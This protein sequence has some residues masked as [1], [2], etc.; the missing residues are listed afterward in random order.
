[1]TVTLAEPA[2]VEAQPSDQRFVIGGVGWDSYVAISDALDERPGMR[3]IYCVGRLIF[4]G[5]SRRH[6]W[7][8][9]RLGEL[10]K[11]LAR[12]LA[13]AWEDAGG[14]TF[15]RE[16]MNAGLEG[17]K[18][19]Y[20]ADHAVQMRGA[21]DIDLSVQ[22]PPDLA[23]EVEVS[24]SAD[25]ALL[26]WGRVGVPEVW[27]YRPKGP[28]LTFCLRAEDGSYTTSERSLGFPAVKPMDVLAQMALANE[29]G[30]DRWNEQLDEWVRD[31]IRSR[32]EGVA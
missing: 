32:L 4:V 20:L 13:I 23:I 12:G 22:P 17:D 24:H 21:G 7:Y 27:K 16:D 29:L 6:D 11:A 18:T 31:V 25:T 1:M 5:K 3:L 2:A 10:V 14:A 30:A 8:A 15:R 28:E 9:E 19:F 26:V